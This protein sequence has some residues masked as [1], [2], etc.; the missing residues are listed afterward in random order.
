MGK[1]SA[2]YNQVVLLSIPSKHNAKQSANPS[3]RFKQDP[4]PFPKW[5]KLTVAHDKQIDAKDSKA[6]ADAVI[7]VLEHSLHDSRVDLDQHDSR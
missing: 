2:P 5:S 6:L 1:T 7:R 4:L 3:P